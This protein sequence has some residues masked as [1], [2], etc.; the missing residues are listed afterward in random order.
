MH[1]EV[2][3]HPTLKEIITVTKEAKNLPL[4]R[5]SLAEVRRGPMKI[6][7]LAGE[8]KPMA[9]VMNHIIHTDEGNLLMRLYYPK[10]N[11][12]LPIVLYFHPGGFVKGDIDSHDP[13]CRN[14][15]EASRCLIASINY[16][17][18]P[19]NP[20]PKAVIAA[21]EALHWIYSH[22]S[23]LNADG[24]IAIAGENAG[25]NLAAVLTQEVR[26]QI[27]PKISF[28]VLVYPQTDFTFSSLSHQ[29]YSTG[30]LLE[31]DSIEWYKKQYVPKNHD[32]MDPRISPLFAHDF[33]SLPPALIITA[34]YDPMRD[35]GEI[36]AQ[37]LKSAGVPTT[38]KR[39]KGM[40]HGFFQ[41]G[42]LLDE[43]RLAINEVGETLKTH[44]SL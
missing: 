11:K 33:S 42:G 44:F 22:P 30:Y 37:K 35:E 20:F 34:E 24:R 31:K 28:Q 23:E 5:I 41:M 29:E 2:M 15:A 9:K 21:K 8:P 3:L 43:A 38:L 36:Y 32:P 4:S 1:N 25:G 39:Y 18:A 10:D 27:H 13:V 17:L 12:P 6:R 14:L 19:E 7:P 26:E 40:V 16:P